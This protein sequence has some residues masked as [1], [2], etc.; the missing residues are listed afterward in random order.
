MIKKALI[1]YLFFVVVIVLSGCSN[2]V[3]NESLQREPSDI[4]SMARADK[5]EVVHFHANQQCWS[6]STVGKYALETIEEKFPEEYESG[7][8]S[9][10]DIN[11]ELV[12]NRDMVRK[13]E[14][15]GS[16][17]FLNKIVGVEEN[18]EEDATVWRLVNDEER[19]K[20]YFEA[21]LKKLLGK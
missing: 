16:S 11:G 7:I 17:L 12:I 21:R 13:Y 4:V 20:S 14:A 6:C 19:F 18:I 3:A 15:R 2:P 5:I 9:F 10:Q 8:I 1:I